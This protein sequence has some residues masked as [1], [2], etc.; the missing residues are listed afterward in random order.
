M[1]SLSRVSLAPSRPL[2]QRRNPKPSHAHLSSKHMVHLQARVLR[3]NTR[4]SEHTRWLQPWHTAPRFSSSPS[5]RWQRAQHLS[6]YSRL[7]PFA[8]RHRRCCRC[9]FSLLRPEESDKI[10]L[11]GTAVARPQARESLD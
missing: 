7:G 2:A 10:Q 11:S 8:P 3:R 1:L 6:L 4:H 5:A 9:V